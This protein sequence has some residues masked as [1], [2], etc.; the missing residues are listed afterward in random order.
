[1]MQLFTQIFKSILLLWNTFWFDSKSDSNLKALSAFRL[2]FCSIMFFCYLPRTFDIEFFY[3]FNGILPGWHHQNV[4]FFRYHPSIIQDSWSVNSILLL[5]S[6]FLGFLVFQAVGLF[7]RFSAIATYFLH[8]MFLNRNMGVMFGVDMIATFFLL[9]LCFAKTNSFYSIDA[10]RKK[11]IHPKQSAIS[12]IALRLMQLQLCIVYGYSGLEKMKGTRWWDGSALWDV[13][14]IGNMQRWD[15]S[16]VSHFPILLAANVYIVLLWEIYFPVLIWQKKFRIPML[17]FGFF[18]HI[19][20]FLFM[21]LPS[22]AFMMISLYILFLKENEIEW[23]KRKT[24]FFIP[25]RN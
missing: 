24:L 8:I 9:Y 2:A 6:I 13:L 23:I 5:H 7:T 20:I 3:S 15:L 10:W 21:N 12:H 16:F 1:M 18:M 4:E 19:G 11:I 22:F 17:V 25:N 14:S